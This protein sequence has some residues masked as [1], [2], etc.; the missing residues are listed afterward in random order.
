MTEPTYK[1]LEDF[2]SRMIYHVF[3]NERPKRSLCNLFD[4]NE[5]QVAKL[6]DSPPELRK[7]LCADCNTIKEM[8]DNDYKKK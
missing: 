7:I 8:I 6:L 4:L 5:F 1:Y 3:V 2:D